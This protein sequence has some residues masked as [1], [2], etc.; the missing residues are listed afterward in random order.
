MTNE[1]DSNRP[2]SLSLV[3]DRLKAK[4]K[5][6]GINYQEL[7]E[8]LDISAEEIERTENLTSSGTTS[9]NTPKTTGIKKYHIE[10]YD[11]EKNR[12]GAREMDLFDFD[13]IDLLFEQLKSTYDY[14]IEFCA[15]IKPGKEAYDEFDNISY[16][17]NNVLEITNIK[18][19]KK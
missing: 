14:V 5:L 13:G 12:L 10:I 8:A 3:T 9:D 18:K 2:P 16:E 6:L 17:D 7:S 11:S 1:D 15:R 19:I 4:R